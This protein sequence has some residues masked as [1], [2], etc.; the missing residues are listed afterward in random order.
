[1]LLD[2]AERVGGRNYKVDVLIRKNGSQ[3]SRDVA[4]QI[5]TVSSDRLASN[6]KTALKQLNGRSGIDPAIGAPES[7]PPGSTRVALIYLEPA[8]WSMHAMGR[9][10]LEWVL[11]R[12][13]RNEVLKDWCFNG[14]AQADEVVIVNQA[15]THR[16]TRDQM[17]TLLR[18]DGL[19]A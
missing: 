14:K 3:R 5:K 18:V 1:M 15:G 13:S 2:G 10:D 9:A 16:W 8:A 4:I 17:N 7:A 6:L 11:G 12:R 19:C